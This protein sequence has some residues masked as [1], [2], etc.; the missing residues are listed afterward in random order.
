VKRFIQNEGRVSGCE[1]IRV[2]RIKQD[3]DRAIKPVTVPGTEFSI[4]ADSVILAVGS[5]ADL[6][7]LPPVLSKS[8]VDRRNHVYRLRLKGAGDRI[9]FYMFGDCASGPRT[10]V[11]ASASGRAA[12]L[13]VF[14]KFCAEDDKVAGFK[15]NYRRRR[16]QHEPDGSEWRVRRTG[17]R[18]SVE[19][20]RGNFEEIDKGLTREC[21]LEEARRCAQCGMFL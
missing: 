12:A 3:S 14:S 21:A 9:K 10:V 20:R 1:A 2:A 5:E 6:K 18:L 11:E 4:R 17:A 15:D 7:C 13:S 16:E 8:V 19:S